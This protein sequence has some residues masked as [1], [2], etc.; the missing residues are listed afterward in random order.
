MVRCGVVAAVLTEQSS[1]LGYD[2]VSW[3]KVFPTFANVR[4]FSPARHHI[5]QDFNLTPFF[6]FSFVANTRPAV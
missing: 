5:M 1:L 3:D 4:N 2:V 6:V